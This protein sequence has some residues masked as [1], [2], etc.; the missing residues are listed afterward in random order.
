MTTDKILE[1]A[2]NRAHQLADRIYQQLDMAEMAETDRDEL[3][4][5][6]LNDPET[7]IE[8]LITRLEEYTMYV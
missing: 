3:E 6:I 7:V 2:R 8:D 5:M 4:S 1:A